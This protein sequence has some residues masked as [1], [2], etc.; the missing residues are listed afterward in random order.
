VL[1]L[2]EAAPGALAD[3]LQASVWEVR[4]PGVAAETAA[5]A[6][7]AFLSAPEV[8]VQ[9]LM[10]NG[11]RTFDARAAVLS[12]VVLPDADAGASERGTGRAD[13]DAA[14]PCAILRVV[15]RHMTPAVRPDDVLAGLRQ[16]ADLVPAAPPGVCR[17][18]QGPLDESTG[19]VG[20]PLAVDRSAVG[21][22]ERSAAQP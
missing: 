1:E 3:R 7:R 6:V 13:S 10:K 5:A 19:T 21:A 12:A 16:V 9:R 8:Q 15:V 17:L 18:A 14:T 11:L 22:T 20:D 2:V 4:L